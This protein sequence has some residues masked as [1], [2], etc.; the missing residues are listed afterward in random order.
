M[1]FG[2]TRG[3]LS[4]NAARPWPPFSRITRHEHQVDFNQEKVAFE[5]VFR[6]AGIFW[7]FV[8]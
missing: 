4:T 7:Y 5:R 3:R 6:V 2:Y 1:N 8:E